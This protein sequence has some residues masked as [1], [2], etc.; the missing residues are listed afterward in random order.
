MQDFSSKQSTDNWFAV[1]KSPRTCRGGKSCHTHQDKN[2]Q[3]KRKAMPR[4]HPTTRNPWS[5]FKIS[6]FHHLKSVISPRDRSS[7]SCEPCEESAPVEHD[8][9]SLS[10]AVAPDSAWIAQLEE[11]KNKKKKTEE[12]LRVKRRDKGAITKTTRTVRFYKI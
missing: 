10:S 3:V 5:T 8:L 7:Y 1:H 4:K 11:K 12:F 6:I 9:T 2:K